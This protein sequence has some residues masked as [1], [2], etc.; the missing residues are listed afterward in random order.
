MTLVARVV[1]ALSFL[2]YL[3]PFGLL[4]RIPVW[5]WDWNGRFSTYTLYVGGGAAVGV[6][7]YLQVLKRNEALYKRSIAHALEKAYAKAE[8]DEAEFDVTRED[9][10]VFSDQHKGTRDGA[11]DFFRSERAYCAA[12]AFYYELD[13]RLVV[14]GDAEELWETWWPD[15]VIGKHTRLKAEEDE[16]DRA[17][18]LEAKFQR[19]GRYERVWGNH[20]LN[21]ERSEQVNKHLVES[22][23]FDVGLSVKEG[24][25]L[26]L[27]DGTEPLGRLFL[28]HGHQGTADSQVLTP[29]S[30]PGVRLFGFLQRR[31]KKGWNTPSNDLKLRER[32]DKAMAAWAE[33]KHGDE[34]ILIAG[35]T[36][37][38]VFWESE[39]E[40]PGHEQLGALGRTEEEA[41]GSG[42]KTKQAEA[43]AAL[44]FAEAD[45]RWG[46]QSGAEEEP[47]PE[48][49]SYF[50]TGCCSFVDG[51]AT[52]LE[53]T[54]GHIRL[55]RWPDNQGRALPQYLSGDE[56][57]S[58]R[59]VFDAIRAH[60]DHSG[61]GDGGG[62]NG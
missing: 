34:V 17:L 32:H 43:A 51:D 55:M 8:V 12:L 37:R 24:I 9:L 2:V 49:P 61:A 6:V 5:I 13:H 33:S 50:N 19:A 1:G 31:F 36:H 4:A 38:P 58:L 40:M 10:V 59:S 60:S 54:N 26:R 14:L 39:R 15:K 44:A 41:E 62:T 21:W 3:L 48:T 52:G 30:R 11:D 45:V 42:D 35:H 53:I 46:R 20:D 22:G 56:P 18:D 57:L 28:V 25:R 23:P 27:T 47:P 7:A 16:D 29:L